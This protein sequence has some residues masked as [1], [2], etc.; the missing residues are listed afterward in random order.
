MENGYQRKNNALKLYEIGY[1]N[2]VIGKTVGSKEYY[3]QLHAFI[4]EEYV[5]Q[6][7]CELVDILISNRQPIDFVAY[8]SMVDALQVLKGRNRQ[9]RE[10]YS[11][12]QRR[13]GCSAFKQGLTWEELDRCVRHERPPFTRNDDN[14]T[15][16]ILLELKRAGQ[17]RHLAEL[18]KIKADTEA[19]REAGITV[20]QMKDDAVSEAKRIV[21][22]AESS[23]EGIRKEAEQIKAEAEQIRAEAEQIKTE[24]EQKAAEAMERAE[25]ST[26][27]LIA[28]HLSGEREAFRTQ[29]RDDVKA[30]LERNREVLGV[31]EEIHNDMCDQTN[32]LQAAWVRSLDHSIGELNKIKEDFYERIRRWQSS[33]YPHELLPLAQRYVELYRIVNVDR[34]IAEAVLAAEENVNKENADKE[35]VDKENVNKEN[36]DKENVNKENAGP[37]PVVESLKK[38]GRTLTIFLR[39]YETS[40][41]GLDMYVFFPEPETAFDDVW[42]VAEDDSVIEYNRKYTVSECIVPGIAKKINDSGE[43]DVIIPAVVRVK[44]EV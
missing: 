31:S 14:R 12:V 33:L 26:G 8:I 23:A 43:D 32:N 1:G 37:S 39:K 27:I 6:G 30:E 10:K 7:F 13:D 41:N 29:L 20:K 35:S 5:Q 22:K 36:A 17:E 11:P 18:S 42:Q 38:L 25:K 34:I 9:N 15:V 19:Y 28:R 4:I 16:N 3:E 44:E 24:A 2:K 21:G 40:L